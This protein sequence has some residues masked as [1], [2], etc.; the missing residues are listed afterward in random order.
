MTRR[1][2]IVLLLE[3]YRDVLHGLDEHGPDSVHVH[4]DWDRLIP[5]MCEA[6]NSP[7]YQQL[8]RLLAV[9]RERWPRL[10]LHLR[11]RYLD[12][13]EVYSGWCKRCGWHPSTAIGKNH[14]HP[15]GRSITVAP[16]IRRVLPVDLSEPELADGLEW[17]E[18]HWSGACEIPEEIMRIEAQRRLAEPAQRAAA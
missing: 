15:P 13:D 14:S 3:H 9:M 6:W 1:D 10:W 8:E 4:G 12:Y 5:A 11:K 18:R 7:A 16:R 2:R 17:L